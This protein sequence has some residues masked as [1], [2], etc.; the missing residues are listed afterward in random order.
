M[1]TLDVRGY[2]CPTPVL[3]VKKEL[4]KKPNELKVLADCGTATEN[5]TR[6]ATN[7]GYKVATKELA[8]ESMEF[9]LTK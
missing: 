6:F 7:A 8:D 4:D 1:Q 3:E 2:S 5:I 9:V